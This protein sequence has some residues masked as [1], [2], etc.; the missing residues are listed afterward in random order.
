[1][2]D[3]NEE[4]SRPYNILCDDDEVCDIMIA[5]VQVHC[6][7][8]IGVHYFVVIL[9]VKTLVSVKRKIRGI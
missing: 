1:M 3:Q 8:H 7:V 2:S 5:A 4:R 6:N 9:V